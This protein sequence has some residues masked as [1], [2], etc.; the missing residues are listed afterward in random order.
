MCY[1]SDFGLTEDKSSCD[2]HEELH[3]YRGPSVIALEEVAALSLALTS[4]PIAS[5]S[6]SASVDRLFVS[7]DIFTDSEEDQ[8]Q[9]L[10]E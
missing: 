9:L 10:G 1:H 2:E 6:S 4:E 5:G 7:A 8:G 3:T